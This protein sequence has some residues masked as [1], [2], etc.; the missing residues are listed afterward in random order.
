MIDLTT[1]PQEKDPIKL[2][3][4]VL[5]VLEEYSIDLDSDIEGCDANDLIEIQHHYSAL[6][7]ILK[8]LVNHICNGKDARGL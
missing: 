6:D 3:Q 5:K 7:N 1:P 8:R 2:F 4:M